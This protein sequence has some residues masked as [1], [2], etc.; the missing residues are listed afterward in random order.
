MEKSFET[1]EKLI[2][3]KVEEGLFASVEDAVAGIC[4]WLDDIEQHY[5]EEQMRNEDA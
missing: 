4:H 1:L 2:L 5:I 3:E